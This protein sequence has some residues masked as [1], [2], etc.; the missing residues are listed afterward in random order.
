MGFI[1]LHHFLK[2]P[3]PTGHTSVK[4]QTPRPSRPLPAQ[5]SLILRFQSRLLR[6]PYRIRPFWKAESLPSDSADCIPCL[7]LW[8]ALALSVALF[9]LLSA[10]PP[11]LFTCPLPSVPSCRLHTPRPGSWPV[12]NDLFTLS[13]LY[14]SSCARQIT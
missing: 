14:P 2:Q 11:L 13:A 9:V 4:I 12:Q 7:A 10:F 3:R 8:V 6:L 5:P 1:H